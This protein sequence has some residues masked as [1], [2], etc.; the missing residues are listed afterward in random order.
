[1]GRRLHRAISATAPIEEEDA[2]RPVVGDEILDDRHVVGLVAEDKSRPIEINDIVANGV[3]VAVVDVEAGAVA[4]NNVVT[5]ERGGNGSALN[6][7]AGSVKTGV[8]PISCIV[9]KARDGEARDGD[10]AGGY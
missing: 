7:N 8:V 9:A 3:A 6:G 10:V 2:D 5:D 4:G 1:M